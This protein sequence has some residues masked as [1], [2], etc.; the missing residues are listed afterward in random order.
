MQKI[1]NKTLAILIAA[2]LIISMASSTVILQSVN[3]T[4]NAHSTAW[5]TAA[6]NPIG[7]GQTT[8]IGMGLVQVNPLSQLLTTSTVAN[9]WNNFKLSITDPNGAISTAGPFTA[10]YTAVS[11]YAFTPTILGN[12]TITFIFPGQLVNDY[13]F[14]LY[15][16]PSNSTITLTVQEEPIL[17][18]PLNPLPTDYWARPINWQNVLW[19]S[20]SG[21][22]LGIQSWT[23]STGSVNPYTTAPA[24]AHIMWTKP[25]EFG[26]QIGGGSPYNQ[27]ETSNYY[28]GK[29]YQWPFTPPVIING[30]LYYNSPSNIAPDYGF[31][32]VDLRN[33][34]TL[35]Y[36]N[37]TNQSPT[38]PTSYG[39][40]SLPV[41]HWPGISYGQVYTY[42][43][44][45]E[46][47]GIPYLWGV[48]GS[49]YSLFDANT[50][51]WILNV[52]GSTG[53][54][55][56]IDP[57]SELLVYTLRAIN[58]TTG[59]LAM[60]NST[61]CLGKAGFA[62]NSIEFRPPSGATLQWSTGVEWNVTVPLYPYSFPASGSVAIG[63]I[64]DGVILVLGTEQVLT[65][66]VYQPQNYQCEAG[67]SAT[68]GQ[69]L[70][71]PVNRTLGMGPETSQ[72]RM[73][74]MADGIYTEHNKED[75][76]YYGFSIHTGQ[77][78]WGPVKG[79]S[80][81]WDLYT[82]NSATL[83]GIVYFLGPE[84]IQAMSLTNGT[85]LWDFAAPPAGVQ[86]AAP[87]YLF[88]GQYGLCTGGGDVFV[89]SSA[90]HGDA[91]FRGAKL[92]A[93]NATTGKE[94]WSIDGSFIGKCFA[95]ADGYLVNYNAYDNQIYTFGQGPSKTTVT[96]PNLGITTATPIT[97]TGT[98][99]DISAGAS[100]QAVAA[101]F[102]NGLP[103]VSDASMSQFMAAVYEQQ[104]MPHN[105][106]GVPV[107][108]SVTDSNGNYREIGTTTSNAY[109]TYSLTWTPDISGNYEVTATFTGS[110]A[111]YPSSAATAFYAS[112][113]AATASPTQIVGTSMADQYFVPAIAGLFVLII[114]VLVLVVLQ[115]FRKR[116]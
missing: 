4:T 90:S 35:W 93:V 55:A 116:P 59:W 112:E 77:Q 68:T 91:L 24:T 10:D 89:S 52:V 8:I 69:L 88:E 73:E 36:N 50:G 34:Q 58:N 13:G 82:R 2:L 102:P 66:L 70:W 17:A 100:Q 27:T 28:T 12:Y 94:Q 107:T 61:K 97:I 56:I 63:G 84:S 57:Q 96:A 25:L 71:G 14:D 115:M 1:K 20:I 51:R 105:I 113:P 33:G 23:E 83:N 80:F 86:E 3:A 108:I 43:N 98:V 87:T 81:A 42:H 30:V 60:W 114:I 21:N 101:N 9:V 19:W 76:T 99:T 37:G 95:L 26:G 38:N 78:L 110:G 47:G 74:A 53:G 44:P 41:T 62:V 11:S 18:L 92:Y 6:P 7:V 79:S 64:N 75:N 16:E 85:F 54:T 49:T 46:V 109:G 32:A 39:G 29:S 72:L 5:I 65:G 48:S 40:F 104:Q 22:W 103:A 15:Y 111:Y 67:Y 45:N 31:Y 106:T